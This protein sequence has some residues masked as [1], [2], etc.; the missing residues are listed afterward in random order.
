MKRIDRYILGAFFRDYLITLSVLLGLWVMMDAFFNADELAIGQ[1]A[2][3]EEGGSLMDALFGIFAYYAAQAI[4]IYAQLAGVVPVTA[5][6]FTLMRMSRFNELVALMAAGLPLWRVAAPVILAAG[7]LNLVIVPVGQ[8]LLIP[9][10]ATWLTLD[11]KEA[12][13]GTRGAFSV[14][15]TPAGTGSVFLAGLFTPSGRS[16]G[17]GTTAEAVTV[18]ERSEQDLSVLTA[19]R[20]TYDAALGQWRLEEGRRRG[21]V[22]P[23]EG[24]AAV[25][26]GP[27]EEVTSWKTPMTPADVELARVADAGVGVGGSYFDL[28]SLGEMDALLKRPDHPAESDLR[29]AKHGRL[30]GHAMNLILLLLAVP[31]VLTRQP[32]QLRRAA[33]RTLL[34]IGGAMASI[35]V[36]RALAGNVP[37]GLPNLLEAQWP[38]IM[39]WMPVFLFGPLAAVLIERMET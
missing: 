8:E 27:V 28:L 32:D 31:S 4:F 25:V 35:F 15:P 19:S 10:I 36:F 37:P 23:E 7:A 11:R 30:A 9:K 1:R 22:V 12:A 13:A 33:G 21:G 18:I 16:G 26:Q 6:A 20:A 39:S 17:D 24:R 34:L 3:A 5:A 29:Q 14:D 38:A 2:D